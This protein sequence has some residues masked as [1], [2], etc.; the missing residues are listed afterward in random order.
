MSNCSRLHAPFY[1]RRYSRECRRHLQATPL[2]EIRERL[3]EVFQSLDLIHDEINVTSEAARSEGQPEI[4]NVLTFCVCN[5]MFEQLKL[6][7]GVI[8]ELVAARICRKVSIKRLAI[9]RR[10][11]QSS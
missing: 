7:T 4:A 3:G 9:P 6:L 5:K 10:R 1:I 8:E 2:I 11:W